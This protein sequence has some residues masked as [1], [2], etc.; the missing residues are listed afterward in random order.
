LVSLRSLD[1]PALARSRLH[2]LMFQVRIESGFGD[3]QLV[4]DRLH[5]QLTFSI[6]CFRGHSGGLRLFRQT[7]RATTFASACSS[8]LETRLSPLAD[9]IALKLGEGIGGAQSGLKKRVKRTPEIAHTG[10]SP[11]KVV[12]NWQEREDGWWVALTDH[13]REALKALD[14]I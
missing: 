7:A 14:I 6:Q 5:T 4:A 11:N 1:F 9:E 13:A 8:S 12:F 10:I 3:V 2:P